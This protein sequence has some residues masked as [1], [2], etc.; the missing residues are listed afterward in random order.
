[1]PSERFTRPT[2]PKI[3]LK[4]GSLLIWGRHGGTAQSL[5]RRYSS[6]LALLTPSL[7]LAQWI[8]S[9]GCW[10]GDKQFDEG[11]VAALKNMATVIS[12]ADKGKQRWNEGFRRLPAGPVD[13]DVIN[14]DDIAWAASAWA[15]AMSRGLLTDGAIVRKT[16]SQMFDR[17]DLRTQ[18]GV[19]I[20]RTNAYDAKMRD[21]K[22]GVA[23]S[24]K[25]LLYWKFNRADA[26]G[27]Y[28]VRCVS[29]G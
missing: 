4:V 24:G 8:G 11:V 20:G 5:G 7:R 25:Q 27:G 19:D 15:T 28:K 6:A 22:C 13:D 12:T 2:R 9:Y 23:G 14:S 17:R 26:G 16:L 21:D 10:S 18:N 1:M 29:S 3:L